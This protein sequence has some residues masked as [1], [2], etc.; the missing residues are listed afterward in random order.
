MGGGTNV[1]FFNLD[2]E[3]EREYERLND[4]FNTT[5]IL[6]LVP[7]FVLFLCHDQNK[8]NQVRHTTVCF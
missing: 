5:V 4:H 8:P 3:R 6:V 2:L 7:G 1:R